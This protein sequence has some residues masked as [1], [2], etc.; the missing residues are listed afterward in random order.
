MKARISLHDNVLASYMLLISQFLINLK[1]F[2][3]PTFENPEHASFCVT[4]YQLLDSIVNLYTDFS[5]K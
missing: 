5:F 2:T 4:V 1:H 3:M